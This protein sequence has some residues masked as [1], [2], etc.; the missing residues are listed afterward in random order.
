MDN[1]Q[2][3]PADNNLV[4]KLKFGVVNFILFSLLLVGVWLLGQL[5]PGIPDEM[6][7]QLVITLIYILWGKQIKLPNK[8]K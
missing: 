2:L 7:I 1:N 4:Q 8:T 5:S 3:K 6:I